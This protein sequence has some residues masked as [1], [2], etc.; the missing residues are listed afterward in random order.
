MSPDCL[1]QHSLGE[2]YLRMG[3]LTEAHRQL[4]G[5]RSSCLAELRTSP[6]NGSILAR[7]AVVEAKLGLGTECEDHIRLAVAAKPDDADVRF[8]EA[9]VKSM[10]N[11]PDEAV[12]A[13][14]EAIAHGYSPR[15]AAQEPHLSLIRKDPRAVELLRRNDSPSTTKGGTS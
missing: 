3:R 14:A 11:K 6:G 9:I 13:L 8:S 7:L 15:R 10:R 5:A 4:E 1:K 2:V 12:R